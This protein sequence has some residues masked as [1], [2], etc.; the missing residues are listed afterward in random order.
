MSA[1]Q[2]LFAR[3]LNAKLT[4]LVLLLTLFAAAGLPKLAMVSDY[5]IFFDDDNQDLNTFLS[6]QRMYTSSDNVLLVLVPPKGKD[7][8]DK[9]AISILYQLTEAGWSLPHVIRVDSVTNYPRTQAEGDDLFVEE[10][11]TD[12]DNLTPEYLTSI[13]AYALQEPLLYRQLISEDGRLSA[14]N[15]V[16]Q[17]PGKDQKHET[18]QLAQATRQL[19]AKIEAENPGYQVYSSG[20]IMLN[21]AFFEAARQDLITLIPL[22]LLLTLCAAGLLLR[23]GLALVTLSIVVVSSVLAALGSAAWLGIFLSAPSVSAPIILLTITVAAGVHILSALQRSVGIT[24]HQEQAVQRAMTACFSPL[25]LTSLTTVIGFLSMNFSDSPPFRDLGNIVALGVVFSWLLSMTVVPWLLLR[26]PLPKQT[27]QVSR[28]E[29]FERLADLLISKR[30]PILWIGLPVVVVVS[31][32]SFKNIP[33][34]DFVNYFSESV[35]FR[36]ETDF[37]NRNLTGIYTIEFSLES[38]KDNGMMEPAALQFAEQFANWLRI[39]PEIVSVSSLTDVLKDINKNMH[40][41]NADYY[42]LPSSREEA[43]QFFLLYEMSLP[44]GKD[45][46]DRINIAKSAI[47]TTA[48]LQNLDSQ[49][50]LALEARVSEFVEKNNNTDIRIRHSSPTVMFSHIG[51]ENTRSLI[52]GALLALIIVSFMLAIMLGSIKL[53]IV[54]IIPNLMP[55]GLAFGVWGLFVGEISMGL[56]GVSSMTIGIVVDDTVHFLYHFLQQRRGGKTAQQACQ[57]SMAKVGPAMLVSSVVL[58]LGFFIL[59]MSSFEKNAAM[60]LLTAITIL[61]ALIADIVI[62]P[63]LLVSLDKWGFRQAYQPKVV[64]NLKGIN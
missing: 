10:L 20:V 52:T 15:L 39:Q 53:G 49:S 29:R 12:L 19:I 22:M 26:F 46:N 16:A 54:S 51:L 44:F 1:I 27:T 62:L 11:V 47:R 58:S 33:N 24:D 55:I 25:G 60:G 30:R 2:G 9:T 59:A 5:R 42:R 13:K 56:A 28:G 50:I 7:A 37:I 21:N 34:D 64:E 14:V 63:S 31:A 18:S 41:G 48:R 3:S 32:F 4:L 43:V 45:L 61:L 23:S 57:Q 6:L 35:P 36:A 17:L 38:H 8:F 40:G